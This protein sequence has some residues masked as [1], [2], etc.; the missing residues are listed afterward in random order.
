VPDMHV[1]EPAGTLTNMAMLSTTSRLNLVSMAAYA[2]CL[3]CASDMS[4]GE[5]VLQVS[6][7][8]VH[9]CVSYLH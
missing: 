4:P 5:S 6:N 2:A 1:G 7:S 8:G 3:V 9:S